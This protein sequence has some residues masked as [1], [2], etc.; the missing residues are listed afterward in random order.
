MLGI[1]DRC[2]DALEILKK[3]QRP[4]G[5][6]QADTSYMKSAWVDFDTPKKSGLWISYIIRRL[7]SI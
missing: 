1:D 7:F 6:W 5:Y 4:D 2:S 3:Q